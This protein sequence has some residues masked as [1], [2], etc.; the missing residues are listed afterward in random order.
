VIGAFILAIPLGLYLISTWLEN[1]PYRISVDVSA[2]LISGFAAV[3]VAMFTISFQSIKA[4]RE[5]P[6]RAMRNE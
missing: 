6:V 4:A 2:V 1:F 5:N 3:F